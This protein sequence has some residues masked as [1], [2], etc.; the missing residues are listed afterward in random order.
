MTALVIY[1]SLYGNT[2]KIARAI[3]AALGTPEEVQVLH[4]GSV[5][6]G[7]LTGLRLLIVGSP[8]QR[9]NAMPAVASLL[10]ELPGKSLEGVRVAAFDTRYPES[11][12]ARTPV[13][14]FFVKLAG[15]GAYAAMHIARS[16]RQKGGRLVVPP[17][18]FYVGGMEGPLLDGELERAA[19]WAGQ[20]KVAG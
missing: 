19:D 3:G 16:L 11:E 20:I 1:D 9:F 8:T 17:E 13:L 7:G 5:Q 14:A 10:K 18:G 2:E 12:I 6:P 4:T 15:R